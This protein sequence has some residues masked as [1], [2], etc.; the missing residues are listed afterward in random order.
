LISIKKF[1][2]LNANPDQ[3]LMH[4]VRILVEGIGEHAVQTNTEDCTMFR[5]TI[6][7]ISEN[8]VDGMS[9]AE[10]LV[11]T[12]SVLHGL[13]DHNRRATRYNRLQTA[14][15]QN[16]VRMLTS[17]V[18]SIGAAST[19]NIGVLGE[20]EK[21]VSVASEL[22]DVRIIKARLAEC[23]NEIQ[24]EARR[25]AKETA[26]TIAQLTEG[27]EQARRRTLNVRRETEEGVICG[28]PQRHEAEAAIAQL[29]REGTGICA[30]MMVV[31]R[32]HILTRRFGKDVG[33]EILSA[34]VQMVRKHLNADDRL[35]RWADPALLALM[36][37][38]GSSI[39]SVRIEFGRVMETK[40]EHTVQTSSRSIMIPISARWL[41]FP[42]IP[43]PRLMYQKLDAFVANAGVGDS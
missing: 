40:L 42:M 22:D 38:P 11:F 7:E 34:F 37:R 17:T 12:G 30:G 9:S 33:D 24:Q 32:M 20:I 36:P 5:E 23:L 28:L 15:L 26:E 27:L 14:E 35:F 19:A 3:A 43:A 39:E 31:D 8:L 29:G 41:L 21:R 10:L 4:V 1:L 6:R 25:Q 2:S 13:E 18:G 16:M